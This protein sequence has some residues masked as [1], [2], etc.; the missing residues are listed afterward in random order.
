MDRPISENIDL[1]TEQGSRK[2]C[3]PGWVAKHSEYFKISA[4]ARNRGNDESFVREPLVERDQECWERASN[5]NISVLEVPEYW[6]LL[7]KPIRQ[8]IMHTKF[9]LLW[10]QL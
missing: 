10:D 3:F 8:T 4:P 6:E 1:S 7:D 9:A 5:V 2:E